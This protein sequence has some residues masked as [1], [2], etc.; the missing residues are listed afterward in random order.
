MCDGFIAKYSL[1][2]SIDVFMEKF[3]SNHVEKNRN[4]YEGAALCRPSTNNGLEGTNGVIKRNFTNRDRLPVGRFIDMICQIVG[5]H[6]E[7][8]NERSS[9]FQKFAQ[10]PEITCCCCCCCLSSVLRVLT[11]SSFHLFDGH[12]RR[13]RKGE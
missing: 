6:S 9:N 13:H 7:R 1:N 5:S 8:H 4:W 3:K 2:E 10:S 11:L 12:R